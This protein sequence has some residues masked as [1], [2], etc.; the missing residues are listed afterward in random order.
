MLDSIPQFPVVRI[1]KK[2]KKI[3]SFHQW[4]KVWAEAFESYQMP[5]SLGFLGLRYHINAW[6][7][8]LLSPISVFLCD[9]ALVLPCLNGAMQ[10]IPSGSLHPVFDIWTFRG[11]SMIWVRFV[12]ALKISWRCQIINQ[13]NYR[14]IT[15]CINVSIPLCWAHFVSLENM[16]SMKLYY[17]RNQ[18]L[19]INWS[20][21]KW[22]KSKFKKVKNS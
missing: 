10:F 13:G 7:W 22:E 19:F 11:D 9:L 4:S 8:S 17:L 15:K 6:T 2:K 3:F 21:T 1:L 20:L 12:F 5:P 14:I 16:F 18:M